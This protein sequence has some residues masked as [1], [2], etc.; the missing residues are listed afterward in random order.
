MKNS[1]KL[2]SEN[3]L[4]EQTMKRYTCT[5]TNPYLYLSID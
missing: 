1:Y 5:L 4:N 2:M 3:P